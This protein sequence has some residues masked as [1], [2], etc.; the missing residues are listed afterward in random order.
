[1]TPR[2]AAAELARVVM[3]VLLLAAEDRVRMEDAGLAFDAGFA[4]DAGLA[5]DAGFAFDAG[6]AFGATLGSLVGKVVAIGGGTANERALM[7]GVGKD[8]CET[9]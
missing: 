9:P 7:A 4:F 3:P 8:C 2:L 5:F 6:L 1:M